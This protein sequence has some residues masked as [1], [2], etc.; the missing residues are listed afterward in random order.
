[1]KLS[2]TTKRK[3]MFFD[4]GEK[5]RA[6]LHTEDTI[7][8]YEN[9]ISENSP[10]SGEFG[11]T[12]CFSGHQSREAHKIHEYYSPLEKSTNVAE[13]SVKRSRCTTFQN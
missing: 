5:V 3:I 10:R 6:D 7:K 4:S 12:N 13:C 8:P 9:H 1:M 11:C 2:F